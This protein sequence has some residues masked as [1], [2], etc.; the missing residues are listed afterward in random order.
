MKILK[1]SINTACNIAVLRLALPIV[2]LI[3][4]FGSFFSQYMNRYLLIISIIF[5]TC[6]VFAQQ[7]VIYDSTA[8]EVRT[9]N[10]TSFQQYNNDA[11]FQY[12]NELVQTPSLWDR[13]WAWV[14][15]KYD[16]IMSTEA[17]R[18]TMKIIFWLLGHWWALHSL[19]TK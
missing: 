16:E 10:D 11:D 9:F 3:C 5:C 12:E 19:Y 13:F 6:S 17:G 1:N 18:A 8:V 2:S 14:W 15:R 4:A 7:K